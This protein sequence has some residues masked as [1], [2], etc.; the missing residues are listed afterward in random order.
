M[1]EN[2]GPW[3]SKETKQVMAERDLAQNIAADNKNEKDWTIYKQMKNIVNRILKD[4]KRNWQRSKFK[5]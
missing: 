1:R 3:L 4:E 2:Y 5:Q